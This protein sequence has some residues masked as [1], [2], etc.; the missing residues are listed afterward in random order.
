MHVVWKIL[1]SI[2]SHLE[3]LQEK[4]W[5]LLFPYKG[6]GVKKRQSIIVTSWS[7]S[8]VVTSALDIKENQKFL[9]SPYLTV[10]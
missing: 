7:A 6:L 3:K 10:L 2:R 4:K 5:W 1:L 9:D 8:C